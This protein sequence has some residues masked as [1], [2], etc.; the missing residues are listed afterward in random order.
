MTVRVPP[1][2]VILQVTFSIAPSSALRPSCFSVVEV[3]ITVE[4][5]KGEVMPKRGKVVGSSRGDKVEVIE[6]SRK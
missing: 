6:M 2:P 1:K 3:V 4:R 5:N